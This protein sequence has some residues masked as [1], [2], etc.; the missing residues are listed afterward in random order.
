MLSLDFR[1]TGRPPD[2]SMVLIS[3]LKDCGLPT[4]PH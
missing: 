4:G 1:I 2:N 3:Y